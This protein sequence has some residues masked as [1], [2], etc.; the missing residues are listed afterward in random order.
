MHLVDELSV[1]RPGVVGVDLEHHLV[2][3]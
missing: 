1:D 3:W 2:I